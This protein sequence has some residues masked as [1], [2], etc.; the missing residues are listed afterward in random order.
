MY[1]SISVMAKGFIL[2]FKSFKKPSFIPQAS[3]FYAS[4]KEKIFR[5]IAN[6]FYS[7]IMSFSLMN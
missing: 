6:Y 7:L 5:R 4:Y 1:L 3:N 2:V